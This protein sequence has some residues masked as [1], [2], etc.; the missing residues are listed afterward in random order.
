[1]KNKGGNHKH[2]KKDSGSRNRK[3]NI[4]NIPVPSDYGDEAV[5]IGLVTGIRGGCHFTIRALNA[6]NISA[7]ETIGWLRASKSRGVRV[8][9]G[10]VVMYALRNYESCEADKMKGD[11]EYIYMPEEVDMLKQLELIPHNYENAIAPNGNIG[12]ITDVGFDFT[13]GGDLGKDE[14]EHI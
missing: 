3:A 13:H 6:E 4:Q 9:V 14:I 8:A 10:T 5:Y 1:M 12:N 11:I 2:M 7:I